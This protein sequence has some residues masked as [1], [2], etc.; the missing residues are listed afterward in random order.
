MFVAAVE[1]GSGVVRGQVASDSAGGEIEGARRLLR[2]IGVADRVV[3]L[4]ALRG[5]PNTARLIVDGGGDYVVPIK[6]NHPTLLDDIR[7][8]DW[9]GAPSRHA[10]DK[11]HGRLE[12]RVCAVAPLDG[13]RDDVAALP[14]RRQAFRIVRRRTVLKSGKTSEE[15]VHGPTSLPRSAPALRRSSPST[16]DTG[17]S[18]TASTTSATSPSTRTAPASAPASCPATSPAS[19]T[20][21]SRSSACAGVSNTSPRRAATTPPGRPTPCA[22]RSPRSSDPTPPKQTAARAGPPRGRL[23]ASRGNLAASR[24]NLR[25]QPR[26]TRPWRLRK[27]LSCRTPSNRI[28]IQATSPCRTNR[29]ALTSG[30]PCLCNTNC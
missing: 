18:R 7:I 20:P 26:K 8:L 12:E 5:C 6:D 24:G 19:P 15:T 4:D 27:P 11:G 10:V 23:A 25:R 28:P 2:E 29:Q 13:V 17:R 30:W 14:G 9:D 3:T 16:A 1:H 21:P 22:K